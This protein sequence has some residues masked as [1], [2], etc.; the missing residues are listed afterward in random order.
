MDYEVRAAGSPVDLE[1]AVRRVAK[2]MDQN[3]ALYQVNT[4]VEEI[5]KSLFQERL[6]ARLTGFFGGLAVL[7]ACVGIY[8]VM[9]FTVVRRTREIGIRMALGASRGEVTGMILRESTR[10][11]V[12]GIVAGIVLGAA[13]MRL[14]S[15]FLY[16]LRPTDPVTFTLAAF[17][18]L[19]AAFL[20]SYIPSRRASKVDPL[21]ALREE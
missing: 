4:Q 13:A 6:F 8:G 10:L 21:I 20:A 11:M 5:N 3:L 7:L 14:V 16:G 19:A 15:S 18:M 9:A 1:S 2:D 17:M 12:I